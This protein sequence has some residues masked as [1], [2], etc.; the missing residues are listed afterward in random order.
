MELTRKARIAFEKWYNEEY[1]FG[2]ELAYIEFDS[3]TKKSMQWG[4]YVD[5]FASVGTGVAIVPHHL[6]TGKI[7]RWDYDVDDCAYRQFTETKEEAR[8]EAIKQAN[9][10]YNER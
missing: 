7:D 2:V 6:N 8:E 9:L 4:V 10:I 5:W 3:L 1:F